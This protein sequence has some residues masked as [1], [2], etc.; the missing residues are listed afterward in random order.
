MI[1]LTQFKDE[2]DFRACALLMSRSEP[3]ITLQR[4]Y[5]KCLQ[6]L[7]GDFKEKYM[8]TENN[9]FAGFVILQIVGSFKGYIQTICIKPEYRNQGIGTTVLKLCEERISKISSNIFM[10]VSSFNDKAQ[11]LYFSL[12]YE[13]VGE[14]KDF[15]IEGHS[16]YLLRK[17]IGKGNSGKLTK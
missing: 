16:E 13:Q 6:S 1:E 4:N 9:E 5:E 3:W 12:G 2:Q 15:I 7:H 8:V 17:I 14:L 11:K 10:C